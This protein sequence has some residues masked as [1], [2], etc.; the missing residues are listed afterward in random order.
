MITNALPSFYCSLYMYVC[1]YV[2]VCNI[3][4]V[5]AITR[6]IL[7]QSAHICGHS[8][9]AKLIKKKVAQA[10]A[11]ATTKTSISVNQIISLVLQTKPLE[12][13]RHLRNTDETHDW[14][15]VTCQGTSKNSISGCNFVEHSNF[16]NSV[17]ILENSV[18]Q[19]TLC[20]QTNEQICL[21]KRKCRVSCIFIFT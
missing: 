3:F 10:R 18:R 9:H 14:L 12:E 16:I 15:R 1:M 17:L 5:Y 4:T 19:H 20:V 6:K 21:S 7:E 8:H 11:F 13:T 2:C